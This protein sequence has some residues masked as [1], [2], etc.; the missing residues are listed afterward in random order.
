MYILA[1]KGKEREGAYSVIDEDKENVLYIFVEEDDATRYALQLED[2][3]YPTMN[4]IEIDDEVMIKTCE[5][6]G[7]KY[8][9]IT[10]NDIVIPPDEI[11]YDFI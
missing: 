4:V 10:P 8:A 9:I 7:H 11:S 6:H 2:R 5:V 3:D 1:R